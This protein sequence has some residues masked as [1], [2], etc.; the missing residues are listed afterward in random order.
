MAALDAGHP[1]EPCEAMIGRL[2]EWRGLDASGGSI[3]A[4]KK[5]GVSI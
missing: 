4:K 3:W 2:R 5:L 1:V